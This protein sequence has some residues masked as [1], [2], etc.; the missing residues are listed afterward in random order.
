MR[1]PSVAERKFSIYWRAI[2]GQQYQEELQ[3][4]EGR[5]WRFDFAWPEVKV[6]LEIEGGVFIGGGHV[7]GRAYT[8]NCEKYN[9]ALFDGWRV[10]RLTPDQITAANLERIKAFL[11]SEYN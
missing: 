8:N 7:R 1:Q 6:A 11:Q 10:F 4:H 5:R 3:F 2:K 9:E